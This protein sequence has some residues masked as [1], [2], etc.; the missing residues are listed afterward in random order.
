MHP[1]IA[2]LQIQIEAR[3][4]LAAYDRDPERRGWRSSLAIMR[5]VRRRREQGRSA[6]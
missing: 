5:D 3:E 6:A 2:E 1:L 4:R